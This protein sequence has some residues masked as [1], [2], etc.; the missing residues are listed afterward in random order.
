MKTCRLFAM[1]A[2]F[3]SASILAYPRPGG[4]LTFVRLNGKAGG[5][6]SGGGWTSNSMI[7]KVRVVFYVDPDEKERN[8]HVGLAIEKAK[9]DRAYY[10]SVA[11]INMGATWLPGFAVARSLKAKQKRYPRTVYVK[12]FEKQLVKR[13]GLADHGYDAIVL[14]AQG[15]VQYYGRGKLSKAQT[16]R[17]VDTLREAVAESKKNAEKA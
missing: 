17:V 10:G 3:V 15:T 14:D 8:D 11:I 16:R 9:L 4:T 2:C 7:G 5:L 1:V 12:D 6:V 13:W